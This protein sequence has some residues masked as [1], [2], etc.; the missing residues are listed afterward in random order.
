MKKSPYKVVALVVVVLLIG[1]GFYVVSQKNGEFV[2][3][4]GAGSSSLAAALSSFFDSFSRLFDGRGSLPPTIGEGSGNGGGSGVLL[5]PKIPATGTYLG[6]RVNPGGIAGDKNDIPGAGEFQQLPIFNASIGRSLAILPIYIGFTNPIPQ[7]SLLASDKNGSIPSIELSC[8]NVEEILSGKD[9]AALTAEATA[10]KTFGK[11]TFMRWY[12]EMNKNDSSHTSRGCDAYNNGANFIAAWKHIWTIFHRVGATNVAF[13]WCPSAGSSDTAQY[14]PGDTY[15][16]WIAG[17][18]FSRDKANKPGFDEI[19]GPFYNQW[20]GH[21][22]P[23]MI[24]ATGAQAADQVKYIQQIQTE[25]PTKYPQFKA[26]NYFDA[27]GNNG[28]FSLQ[29]AG[30]TAFKTLANTPYFLY[31]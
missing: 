2:A 8:A 25:L 18:G 11:P 29:G 3:N 14:Y 1:F 28:D 30:L 17:D 12:W 9:D 13:V 5:P 7:A 6:A 10:L 27:N 16:D 21:N 15:V 20:V 31:R 26:L 22:K 24:G 4:N 23:M 19:F